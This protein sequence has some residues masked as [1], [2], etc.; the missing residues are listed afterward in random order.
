MFDNYSANVMI[1]G[2]PIQL[3]L[4]DTSGQED[5]ARLRPLSYPQTNVFIV[6]YSI[7]S[8]T[9]YENVKTKWIPEIKHHCPNIPFV[10]VVTHLHLRNDEEALKN[11][12]I[13][14]NHLMVN[15]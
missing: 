4:W 1:D 8:R 10:L 11:L 5:Y 6:V 13:H 9:S 15:I 2:R 3:G 14:C 12:E 7:I